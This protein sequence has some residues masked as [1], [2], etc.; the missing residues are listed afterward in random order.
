MRTIPA[1]LTLFA[2]CLAALTLAPLAVAEKPT[3]G[4]PD[5]ARAV[6]R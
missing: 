3:P 4:A 6:E 2:L 5:R 1:R